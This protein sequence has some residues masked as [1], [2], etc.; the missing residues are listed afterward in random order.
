MLTFWPVTGNL[1]S[2]PKGHASFS[3][4]QVELLFLPTEE[5]SR[6]TFFFVICLQMD[7]AKSELEI[8]KSQYETAV[9]QLKEAKDNLEKTLE[10]RTDRKR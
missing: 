9:N 4:I 5:V 7:V 8:Y 10:T 1:V 6:I 3:R 2:A